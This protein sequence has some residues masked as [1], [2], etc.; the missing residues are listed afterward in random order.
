MIA[1]L[2]K[3]TFVA[4]HKQVAPFLEATWRKGYVM[5]APPHQPRY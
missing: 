5:H 2:P 3:L 1:E 4:Q